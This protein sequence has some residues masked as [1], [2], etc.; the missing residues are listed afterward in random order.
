MSFFA[1]SSMS[2]ERPPST[3]ECGTVIESINGDMVQQEL[4]IEHQPHVVENNRQSIYYATETINTSTTTMSAPPI[5]SKL[6]ILQQNPTTNSSYIKET[7][8]KVVLVATE[9][10]LLNYST[11]KQSTNGSIHSI[12]SNTSDEDL[13]SLTWLHDSN[14]LK[15]MYGE[16]MA[17]LFVSIYFICISL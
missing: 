12:T 6:V 8:G 9:Q 7:D 14:V 11:D 2:P 10:M 5:S 16:K 17:D 4:I 13:T 1:L 15:G 3:T